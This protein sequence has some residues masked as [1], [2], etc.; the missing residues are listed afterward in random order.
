MLLNVLCMFDS[1]AVQVSRNPLTWWRRTILAW[2]RNVSS[3]SATWRKSSRTTPWWPQP[4]LYVHCSLCISFI[5]HNI[6]WNGRTSCP[7]HRRART[8]QII[9]ANYVSFVICSHCRFGSSLEVLV[10][11][12]Q[13]GENNFRPSLVTRWNS[14]RMSGSSRVTRTG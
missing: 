5:W 13:Q 11:N 6:Q 12:S 14:R 10:Y 3:C 1:L 2:R 9:D 7:L 8:L 4:F